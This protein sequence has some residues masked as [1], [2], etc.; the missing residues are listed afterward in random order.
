MNQAGSGTLSILH[1][2]SDLVIVDKPPG[3]L[4]HVHQFDRASP[5]VRAVLERKLGV[6]VYTVHR[7]DRMTTGLLVVALNPVVAHRLSGD[8]RN[9]RIHKSYLALVRGHTGP[10]FVI[11]T[12][13]EQNGRPAEAVSQVHTIDHGFVSEAVGRYSEAWFSLVQV[14]TLTG[15]RHQ[16]RRH[17]H[18]INHPV[19]GDRK[20]GDKNYNAWAENRFG[21][22]HLYLRATELAFEH[23]G[24][25]RPVHAVAGLP[26][27][28]RKTLELVC[29]DSTSWQSLPA[30][31]R[32]DTMQAP[33]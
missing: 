9:R 30:D 6:P 13:L 18:S 3:M 26:G 33:D 8:F 11:S 23:P 22:R 14:K 1:Q 31:S 19:I 17:L 10:E 25:G 24:D 5:N 27:F 7:L 32:V 4:T 21:A 12:P 16:I 2:D 28:W 15:R 29:P 20:H